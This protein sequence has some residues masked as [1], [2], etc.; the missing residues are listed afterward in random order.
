MIDYISLCTGIGGLE[1]GAEMANAALGR[2]FYAPIAFAEV[3][4]FCCRALKHHWPD[5]P[6]I[7]DLNHA[8]ESLRE[9]GIE[10]AGGVFGGIPCQPHSVAG[11]QMGA[12]DER[13]L[14]PA[15][16]AIIRA[17]QPRWVVIENVGGFAGSDDGLSRVRHDLE[18]EGYEVGSV[19]IPACAVGA[20]HER[21]RCFVMAYAKS[22]DWRESA[23]VGVLPNGTGGKEGQEPCGGVSRS[24][25]STLADCQNI[26]RHARAGLCGGDARRHG[27][28]FT[29]DG[30]SQ[31]GE[32]MDDAASE[33]CGTGANHR[34]ER[35]VQNNGQWHAAQIQS[36][37]PQLL[38]EPAAHADAATG[39]LKTLADTARCGMEGN[40]PARFE[41]PQPPRGQALPGRDGAGSAATNG[42]FES[43]LGGAV[44][45]L[46][47][48]M[49]GYSRRFDQLL[50]DVIGSTPIPALMGER[51]SDFEAPRL[52]PK[53]KQWKQKISALG[54]A[55]VPQQIFPILLALALSEVN[56]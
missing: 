40:R 18:N 43:R 24:E 46:S 4:P 12:A 48:G 35:H 7:G 15:A 5:V 11:K 38:S 54:N 28:R 14:W 17:V 32:V 26:G 22:F 42:R 2:K 41:Q 39:T 25:G 52:A 21:M 56:G 13:D 44:D 16:L 1:L 27:R 9:I 47:G 6:N 45:G 31:A 3:E 53:G 36:E 55:I 30:D 8:V 49:A 10:R 19:E 33:R 34:Q 51:Q 20:S 29:G 50:A 23:N 37:R